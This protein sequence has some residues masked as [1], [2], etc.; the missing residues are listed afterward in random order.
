M[1]R[2]Q[3][4]NDALDLYSQTPEGLPLWKTKGSN[5]SMQPDGYRLG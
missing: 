2:V 4:V 3:F 1:E 5:I